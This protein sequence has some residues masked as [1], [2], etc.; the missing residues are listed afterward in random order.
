MNDLLWLQLLWIKHISPI[1]RLTTYRFFYTCYIYI[2]PIDNNKHPDESLASFDLYISGV[3]VYNSHYVTSMFFILYLPRSFPLYSRWW[4]RINHFTHWITFLSLPLRFFIDTKNSNCDCIDFVRSGKQWSMII[5][6][7]LCQ[8]IN[9]IK[10][11]TNY[12]KKRRKKS[13]KKAKTTDKTAL[14]SRL[15]F[16]YFIFW[17]KR[18][19]KRCFQMNITNGRQTKQSPIPADDWTFHPY[20]VCS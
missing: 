20:I 6:A 1:S 2:Y 10:V 11:K 15:I 16:M 19:S 14:C 7:M 4:K 5:W 12:A 8:T 13:S 9:N 17:T 18:I 3:S